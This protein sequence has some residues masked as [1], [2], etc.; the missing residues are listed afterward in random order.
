MDEA[1]SDDN[2][3]IARIVNTFLDTLA[4]AHTDSDTQAAYEEFLTHTNTIQRQALAYELD[5]MHMAALS[6]SI[7][8]EASMFVYAA[9]HDYHNA[10]RHLRYADDA[11]RN[12]DY[13]NEIAVAG[14]VRAARIDAL[15]KALWAS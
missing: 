11:Q 1:Y 9:E 14:Y 5:R 13:F 10:E 2:G 12:F 6:A 8:T 4:E 3:R 15:R 7:L